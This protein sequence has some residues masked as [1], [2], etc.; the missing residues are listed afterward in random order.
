MR[1]QSILIAGLII[2]V[3]IVMGIIIFMPSSS[4][5]KSLIDDDN[6][7]T[8]NQNELNNASSPHTQ[9]SQSNGENSIKNPLSNS[10]SKDD[11]TLDVST[12]GSN[13]SGSTQSQLTSDDPNASNPG[14]SDAI[15]DANSLNNQS[16]SKILPNGIAG[17]VQ[18]NLNVPLQGAAIEIDG[19][20]MTF[21]EVE[22][23]FQIAK[24]NQQTSTLT[25]KLSGYQPAIRK[26]VKVG[27]TNIVLTLI[28]EGMLAGRVQDQFGEPIAIAQ[29]QAKALE[30]IWVIDINAD[31]EGRFSFDN[32]PSTRIRLQ[33]SQEGYTNSGNGV[34]EVD[35]PSGNEIMLQLDRPTYSISGHIIA[36]DNQQGISGFKLRAILQK[37]GSTPEDN[38]METDAS[39][40][41]RFDNLKQGTYLVSSA[42]KENA[43]LNYVIPLKDDF[44]SVRL[45]EKNASNIDFGAV[46]GRTVNGLVIDSNNQPVANAEVTIAGLES[47]QTISSSDG[48]FHLSGVPTTGGQTLDNYSIRLQASHPDYGTGLSDPLPSDTETE[49]EINNITIT[50]QGMTELTGTVVDKAG[51]AVSDVRISL[52]DLTQNQVQETITDGGGSFRFDQVSL[53]QSLNTFGGTHEIIAEKEEYS[54]VRKQIILQSQ[55]QPIT[56]TL[57]QGGII[58]GRVLDANGQPLAGVSVATQIPQSGVANS[59]SDVAGVYNL[60]GLPE[61]VYDIHFRVDSEPPLTGV[62][63]QIAAGSTGADVSLVLGEWNLMGTIVDSDTNKLIHQYMLS[64]EGTPKDQ[65]GRSFV[66]THQVNTP[67]GTYQLTFT[68][69]GIYRIRFLA[70][71]YHPH[72]EKVDIDQDTMRLQ[73]INPQLMSLV[74]TGSI[75]GR[76]TGPSNATLS[77]INIPGVQVFPTNGDVF[78][79]ENIPV[80]NHDLIFHVYEKTTN[81]VYEV[82]V[83]PNITVIEDDLVDLGDIGLPNLTIYTRQF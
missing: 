36:L 43:H 42:A 37:A 30:G 34:K 25:A 83:L 73:Y 2:V 58:N 70:Q 46:S 35:L 72:D 28:P 40:F 67:D 81:A 77:G 32:T 9:D 15:K 11:S 71:G 17:I 82:G 4:V 56:L 39:G 13:I 3:L 53:S 68:E 6:A 41:Y 20:T 14:S 75:Q 5:N 12:S 52:R 49:T 44:K 51:T 8:L 48:R 16:E 57:E 38:I 10:G 19:Q 62:L 76:F 66:Q 55:G 64:V 18:D 21:S 31:A 26:D 59:I 23:K 65:R 1:S 27:S 60:T 50:L 63:Y 24:I 29:V 61:G 33:A 7:L 54:S 79:L 78:L 69:P 74:N 80:G 45:F 22:G 47:V